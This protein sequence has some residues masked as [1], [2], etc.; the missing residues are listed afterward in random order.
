MKYIYTFTVAVMIFFP[1]YWIDFVVVSHKQV[2][3]GEK[4]GVHYAGGPGEDKDTP[5]GTG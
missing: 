1:Y 5:L 2:W 4:S 3:H